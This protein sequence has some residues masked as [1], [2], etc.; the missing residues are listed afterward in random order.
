MPV[1]RRPRS[2]Q[3]WVKPPQPQP[4]S[5]TWPPSPTRMES[6]AKRYFLGVLSS[7]DLS[8][9][10]RGRACR[11]ASP[12]R[13]RRPG[14]SGVIMLG[15]PG[16]VQ[17]GAPEQQRLQARRQ[18]LIQR[19]SSQSRLRNHIALDDVALDLEVAAYVGLGDGE[20]V[21]AAQGLGAAAV[22][23]V[24]LEGRLA[25][26]DPLRV[27]VH[28]QDERTGKCPTVGEQPG[29]SR[30]RPFIPRSPP[31]LFRKTAGKATTAPGAGLR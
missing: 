27:P 9:S 29:N 15:D 24:Q 18:G 13:G 26:A 4:T 5:R 23:D 30:S 12:G 25:G 3:K 14:C 1:T 21:E 31:G 8:R 11:R 20:L 2:E 17:L 28:A 6:R 22:A 19:L 16:G 10:R 7:S